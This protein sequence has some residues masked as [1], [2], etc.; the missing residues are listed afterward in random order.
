MRELTGT[1]AVKTTYQT[2]LGRRSAAQQA[3]ILGP[4]RADL[5][6]KGNLSLDRFVMADGTEL[7]LSQ[8]ASRHT[9]AF[10]RAGL[11]PDDFR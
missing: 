7:T 5:F 2:W 10:R 6:R 11:D 4:T 3:D 8:L 9:A 1:T